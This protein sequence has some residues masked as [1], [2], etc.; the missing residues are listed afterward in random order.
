MSANVWLDRVLSMDETGELVE[1]VEEGEDEDV[2]LLM[3]V[4]PGLEELGFVC[5]VLRE[6][7]EGSFW[8]LNSF[9]LIMKRLAEEECT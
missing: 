8:W 5:E 7:R 9:Q 6:R 2:V 4:W 1:G 3:E